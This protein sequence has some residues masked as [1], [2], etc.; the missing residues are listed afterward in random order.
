MSFPANYVDTNF[1][2]TYSMRNKTTD[3][4]GQKLRMTRAGRIRTKLLPLGPAAF[5]TWARTLIK[6][7]RPQCY[8]MWLQVRY[9]WILYVTF[10]LKHCWMRDKCPFFV[11]REFINDE[12]YF[13]NSSVTMVL[14]HVYNNSWGMSTYDRKSICEPSAGRRLVGTKCVS[15]NLF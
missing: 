15:E 12:W 14:L 1:S 4:A 11:F 9:F 5:R 10:T 8:L 3:T 2:N 13:V 6:T 7:P